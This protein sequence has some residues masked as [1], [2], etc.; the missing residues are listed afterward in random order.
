[1]QVYRL[2]GDLWREAGDSE[3]A[4]LAYTS[5]VDVRPG[6]A[7]AHREL[8]RAL[9][10][11]KKYDEA[12]AQFER[13][14]QLR[15]EEPDRWS[16][17]AETLACTDSAAA[18]RCYEE[19]A[20][21]T[22]EPRFQETVRSVQAG[23]QLLALE[24]AKRAGDGDR[25]REIRRVLSEYHVPEGLYDLK[26]IMTWDTQ[27][28]I[29]LDILDPTGEHVYHGN[30]SSKAGGKYWVD[31]TRGLGPETFTLSRAPV[32]VYRIGAHFHSGSG[33]TT[34]RFQI[35]LHEE[36]ERERRIDHTLVLEHSG[37]QQYLPDVAEE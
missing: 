20:K 32:G 19:I 7:D 1:M 34:V 27:T 8:G 2:L 5:I 36:T 25:V 31:N 15:P 17:I 14:K 9:R 21:R 4:Y 29:D 6:D 16:D 18:E 35:L 24:N 3:R 37:E 10:E 26:V 22:W 11:M 12:L 33:R 13:S 23:R 28:D 30:S